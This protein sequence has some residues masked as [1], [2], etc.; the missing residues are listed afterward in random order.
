MMNVYSPFKLG[1]KVYSDKANG[2]TFIRRK[3][4][5]NTNL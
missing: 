1:N 4:N 2:L 3:D 5:N